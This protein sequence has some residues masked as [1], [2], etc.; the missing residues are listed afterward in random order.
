MALFYQEKCLEEP[1]EVLWKVYERTSAF[2]LILHSMASF[3]ALRPN[4]PPRSDALR[5]YDDL[6]RRLIEWRQ[7]WDASL[8]DSRYG[9]ILSSPAGEADFAKS[10]EPGVLFDNPIFSSS[11][12]TAEWH[13]MMM[14]HLSH[15]P[16]NLPGDPQEMRKHAYGA[17]QVIGAVSQWDRAPPGALSM[18]HSILLVALKF[19]PQDEQHRFWVRRKLALIEATGYVQCHR[20]HNLLHQFLTRYQICLCGSKERTSSWSV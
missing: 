16:E 3:F 6:T 20:R 1:A 12:C 17:C 18:L 11:I 4:A 5:Q 10:S 8:T 9:V 7:N 14:V 2:R 13:S 19:L 15:H